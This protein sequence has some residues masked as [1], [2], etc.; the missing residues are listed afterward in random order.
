MIRRP[1]R[2]TLFPYTTLFRSCSSLL[3]ISHAYPGTYQEHYASQKGSRQAD[4]ALCGKANL[5]RVEG[6]PRVLVPLFGGSAIPSGSL[7]VVPWHSLSLGIHIAD[8]V[9]SFC[10][11]LVGGFAIPMDGLTVV[12]RHSLT[13][14]IQTS[15]VALSLRI[16][17]VGGFAVPAGSLGVV[18]RHSVAMEILVAEVGLSFRVSLLGS[19]PV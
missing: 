2:S 17:L 3:S 11:A 7:S 16:A 18:Q 14:V 10:I 13:L 19:C 4:F 5:H 8:G 9:L 12:L 6:A 15:E 1:P